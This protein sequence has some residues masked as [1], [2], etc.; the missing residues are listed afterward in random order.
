MKY[1]IENN[2]FDLTLMKQNIKNK[3]NTQTNEINKII[4]ILKSNENNKIINE[5]KENET[6]NFNNFNNFKFENMKNI[7]TLNNNKGYI[8]CLKTLDDGRLAAGDSDS[9]FNYL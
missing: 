6:N 3:L 4:T 2:Y 9:Y 7:K 8:E 5:N 1:N